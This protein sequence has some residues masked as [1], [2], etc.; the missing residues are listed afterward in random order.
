MAGLAA[1]RAVQHATGLAADIRWPND[2]LL[3]GRKVA[4]IL[5]EMNAEVDRVHAVV[6]GI[7]INVNHTRMPDELKAIAS[8]L[9]LEGGRAYSRSQILVSLLKEMERLYHQMMGE[10][11]EP[12]AKQWARAS[13]YAHDKRVCVKRNGQEL[14]AVTQRPPFGWRAPRPV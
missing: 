14:L 4:G 1:Q 9:R 11:I 2:L 5:T 10:G 12:I 6:I 8:S 7:G 13:S 3:N